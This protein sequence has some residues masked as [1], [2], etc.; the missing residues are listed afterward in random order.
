MRKICIINQKGG[1]GKTTTA[2]N[3]ATG[4]ARK[5]KKVLVLDMDPQG[6]ISTCLGQDS[7]KDMY[8][9]LVNSE[10]PREISKEVEPNLFIVTAS[11]KLAEAESIMMGRPN[12]ERILGRVMDDLTDDDYDF[13]IIDCP[14][15]I[16]LLNQNALLFADEALIP[17]A[18]EKLSLVGLQKMI[19]VIDEYNNLFDHD[20]VIG[21]ILPT[22]YDRRNRVCVEV[23]GEMEAK[24]NGM[25]LEPI[26]VNSKLIEAPGYAKSIFDYAK[27]S[28]GAEDYRA[29]VDF[30]IKNE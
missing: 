13:I 10:D 26:R 29:L 2:V 23:L 22:M 21:G 24:F 5:K 7:E 1:V 3:L 20:L 30:V 6:N 8:E 19:D 28:R 12:R 17:S 11:G 15:S 9:L 18:T 25:T 16:N 4:L 14:P 27:S